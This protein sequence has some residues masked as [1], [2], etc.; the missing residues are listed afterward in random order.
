MIR[1]QATS[2]V[3]NGS[4]DETYRSLSDAMGDAHL[5]LVHSLNKDGKANE[6]G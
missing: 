3:W 2:M 5:Q 6:A 1:A 4:E